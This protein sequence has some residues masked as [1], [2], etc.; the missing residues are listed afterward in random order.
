VH[1]FSWWV[2]HPASPPAAQATPQIRS[3]QSPLLPH[4]QVEVVAVVAQPQKPY[5]SAAPATKNC[6]TYLNESK[7]ITLV[8]SGLLYQIGESLD[9][10]L[11]VEQL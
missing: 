10:P 2:L 1:F 7:R 11:E 8:N 5:Y 9:N 3:P 4:H 6:S